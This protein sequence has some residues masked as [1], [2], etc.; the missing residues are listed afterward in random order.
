VGKPIFVVGH[1]NPD[2]DAISAAIGFAALKNEIAKRDGTGE[3]YEAKR[4][5]PLPAETEW[6]IKEYG[7][8]EPELIDHIDAPAGEDEPKQ[9]VILVDHNEVRQ[10]VDGLENAE[11]IEIVDHHRIGDVTTNNPIT[12]TNLPV[13]STA[14]IV[15][16]KYR[17]AGITPSK[18]VAAALLGAIMTDT[19]IL[20]S[21][22][23]TDFDRK[24]VDYLA[25]IVGVDYV[26]YGSGLF[27]KRG[28]EE[29]LPIEK[30]VGADAKEFPFGDKVVYIAQHE[31]VDLE[32]AMKRE[33][34]AREYMRKLIADKG[35]DFVLL[36][37][38]DIINEG[39]MF[40]VEGDVAA[41]EKIFGITCQKGGTW[42]PG[43][44]S[45]KKQVAA[46]V[47]EA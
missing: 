8:E 17:H 33:D 23:A 34:E 32:G 24:Q 21:P 45:R 28:G 36:M 31:T 46:R 13:G 41:V 42:M 6:V 14:T 22:T 11:I 43:V 5:G 39:S 2:N 20:K 26:E 25:P 38:T 15:T 44:M 7:L 12:F 4:L 40:V 9:R 29:G 10:A 16:S 30:F 37:V 3:V 27:K 19:V 47:L 18:G 35:Y 1:K